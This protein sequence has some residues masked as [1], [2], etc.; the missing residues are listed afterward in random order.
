MQLDTSWTHLLAGRSRSC[1]G[2][3]SRSEAAKSGSQVHEAKEVNRPLLSSGRQSHDPRSLGFSLT[4]SNLL[5]CCAGR[6]QLMGRALHND[7][8]AAAAAAVVAAS[9][10]KTPLCDGD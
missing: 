8:D 5:R 3:F 4:V 1:L 2:V 9:Y 6:G 7:D 10:P